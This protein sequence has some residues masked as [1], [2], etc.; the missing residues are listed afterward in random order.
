MIF[1][2]FLRK[3]QEPI[4]ENL[5]SKSHT[6]LLLADSIMASNQ[7]TSSFADIATI[8]E[9]YKYMRLNFD[10]SRELLSDVF[11]DLLKLLRRSE[12]TGTHARLV[13]GSILAG[14]DLNDTCFSMEYFLQPHTQ[15][16]FSI[17][18]LSDDEYVEQIVVEKKAVQF[19]YQRIRIA[20]Y[21]DTGP[22]PLVVLEKGFGYM[23]PIFFSPSET[24]I[25]F[26]KP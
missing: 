16:I 22:Q 15:S 21:M 2:K 10:T 13:S 26:R 17:N 8:Y 12:T 24:A 14:S 7:I 5:G 25:S 20:R 9:D 18:E 19:A 6:K 11:N 23:D 4:L 1:E 3:N